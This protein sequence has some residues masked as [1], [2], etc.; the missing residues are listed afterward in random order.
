M[1]VDARLVFQSQVWNSRGSLKECTTI[2]FSFLRSLKVVKFDKSVVK[3]CTRLF[4]LAGAE[5][6]KARLAKADST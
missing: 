2:K 4:Q 3:C 1:V 5:W 6:Q